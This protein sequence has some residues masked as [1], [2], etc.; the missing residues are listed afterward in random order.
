MSE[1]RR[2]QFEKEQHSEEVRKQM[3]ARE[4]H[5]INSIKSKR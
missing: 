2:L 5:R 4:S 1:K 3:E